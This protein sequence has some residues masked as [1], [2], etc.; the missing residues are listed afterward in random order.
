MS[1]YFLISFAV[2]LL[3]SCDTFII[4]RGT[5]REQGTGQPI[6]GATVYEKGLD[7]LYKVTDA[8]GNF[9][10]VK[11]LD[12]F[13][14]PK[15]LLYAEKDGYETAVIKN[16]GPKDTIY[17]KKLEIDSTCIP[18]PDVLNGDTVY[19]F[20]DKMPEF[21]G[22]AEEMMKYV[23]KNTK[24]IGEGN[25]ETVPPLTVYITFVVDTAGNVVNPCV[26][27]RKGGDD[28]GLENEEIL[29]IFKTMPLWQPGQQN[30]KNVNVRMDV[31][32]RWH[33]Q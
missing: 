21:E 20:V 31:P 25:Y 14:R 6:S 2:A 26:R 12:F 11:P 30:G 9:R 16:P 33:Y 4:V 19:A 23:L 24:N 32:V 29:S 28:E 13:V 5:V 3:S 7:D 15:L 18:K 27:M 10:Y 22:G 17:L 8:N 1:K